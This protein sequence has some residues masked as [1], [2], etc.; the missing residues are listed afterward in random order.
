MK[1]LGKLLLVLVL[2]GAIV[3]GLVYV[4]GQLRRNTEQEISDYVVGQFG[5][6]ATTELGGWPF[7]AARFSNRLPD[8][9]ITVRDATVA[10]DDRTAPIAHAELSAVGLA[11][12]DDLSSARAERLD[13]RVQLTWQ[14][15]TLLVGFPVSH[16]SGDRISAR[17]S[18]E[19]FGVVAV[20][21]LQAELGVEADGRLTLSQ[22]T[23]SAV[24]IDIPDEL[25][26]LAV[27]KL[28]PTMQLPQFDRLEYERLE[29]DETGITAVLHGTDVPIALNS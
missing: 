12:V 1:G 18:I 23:A 11:P 13:A 8:A 27:D 25:V 3:G 14:E 28:A 20:A 5:G 2:L 29:I 7:V 4:D 9:K 24:N 19:V 22:P 10:V 17:T 21:E 15:L 16:V 6:E 26:Q